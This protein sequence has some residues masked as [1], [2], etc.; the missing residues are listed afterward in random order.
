MEG[1]GGTVCA[2]YLEHWK[3][4]IVGGF[5][6]NLTASNDRPVRRG[7]LPPLREELTS[8]VVILS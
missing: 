3:I 8:F 4:V 6:V 7:T 5:R 1:V 2:R